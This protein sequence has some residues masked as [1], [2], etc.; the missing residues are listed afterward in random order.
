MKLPTATSAEFDSH[1]EEHN[2]RCLP[3]TRV[4]LRHT[5]TKWADDDGGKYIFWLNGMAGTGK[6]TISRTMAQYFDDKGCLGA[7]FFFKRG[8]GDRGNASR[9]F[10]TIAVRL[11]SKVP[12]LSRYI[13]HAIDAEPGIAEKALNQQFEKLILHPL[14]MMHGD[15]QQASRLVIVIDALDECEREEDVRTILLLLSKHAAKISIYLRIFITS[16]PE[17]PI[18]LGFSNMHGGT[19]QHLVLNEVSQITIEHDILV[20]FEDQFTIIRASRSLSTDWP[21]QEDIQA[22]VEMAVPL[23]IFAATV[24]RFIGDPSWNPKKQLATILEYR[25]ASQ[26]SKLDMTYMPILNQLFAEK[27]EVE[28]EKLASEFR[29]IVGAIV[30][31]AN[32][33]ST[34]AL[35]NIL[36][37]PKDD[38]AYRIG[39]LHSVLNIPTDQSHPVRLLHLSFRD[40]LLDPMKRGKSPFWINEKEMHRKIASN[41]IQLLSSCLKKDICSMQ[42]PGTLR[43][44]IDSQVIHNCLPTE[45]QYACRYWIFHLV[46]IK[47]S[48]CD[49]NEIYG[50]LQEHFLHWLE[51]MCLLGNVSESI[52][53]I[54][55]LEPILEVS[56]P[57]RV[58]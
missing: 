28:S 58:S 36:R 34:I 39:L 25:T 10:A 45:A 18:R 56:L 7:S 51:A 11:A 9:F 6:S 53:S 27:D 8:E 22:L 29:E 4:D 43:S 23:F 41:C 57:L 38:I 14:S 26:A 37:I 42:R 54:E 32:P 33:L 16:R 15:S 55:A 1:V 50:F 47:S 49:E 30:T 35:A 21:R 13:G 24:C 48:I 2:A 20:F 5:I 31:L 52:R 3:N 17:L 19:Y 40:F 46:E 44:D 12:S